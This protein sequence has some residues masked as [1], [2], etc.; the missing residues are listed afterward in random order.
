MCFGSEEESQ[1]EGAGNYAVSP[2][3]VLLFLET[4][5]FVAWTPI[6]P[7]P[8]PPSAPGPP[9]VSMAPNHG[10]LPGSATGPG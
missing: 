9:G 2:A 1:A 8:S 3:S 5:T 7:S 6:P 10:H 4:A